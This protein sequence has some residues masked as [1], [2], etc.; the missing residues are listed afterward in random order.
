M[1]A[2]VGVFFV[3]VGVEQLGH[4]RNTAVLYL[5]GR[6]GERP[7]SSFEREDGVR[8]SAEGTDKFR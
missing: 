8:G 2:T 7:A 4:L 1:Q 3:Y 6:Q 5:D